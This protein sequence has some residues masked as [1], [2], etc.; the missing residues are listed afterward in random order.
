ML[1]F[2]QHAARCSRQTQVRACRPAAWGCRLAASARPLSSERPLLVRATSLPTQPSENWKTIPNALTLGRIAAVPGF[3]G[4]WSVG[5]P[6]AAAGLFGAAAAT[7]YLDG[8][9]ARRWNQQTTLGELLDPLADKLLVAAALAVLVE[10]GGHWSVTLPAAAILCRELVV[11]QLRAWVQTHRAGA[12]GGMAVA[13]HGKAKAALQMLA[14]QV[15]LLAVALES[16]EQKDWS[17]IYALGLILLWASSIATVAS[18]ASYLR[19]AFAA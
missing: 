17:T 3:L 18:G 8:Y 5:M 7:D 11:P 16:H 9:L 4:L 12:E 13:W 1:H 10:H 19:I 15:M 6:G 2:S 14:L